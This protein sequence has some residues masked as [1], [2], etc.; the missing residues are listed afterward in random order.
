VTV[1]R[2]KA[3][4]YILLYVLPLEQ[5][6]LCHYHDPMIIRDSTSPGV[7]GVSNVLSKMGNAVTFRT[8]FKAVAKN[9]ENM[10]SRMYNFSAMQSMRMQYELYEGLHRSKRREVLNYEPACQKDIKE[11]GKEI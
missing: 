4:L 2:Q 7:K 10:S 3:C 1:A 5:C 6:P 9:S 11:G 8:A